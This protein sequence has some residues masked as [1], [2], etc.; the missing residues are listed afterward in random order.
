MPVQFS[1]DRRVGEVVDRGGA[2]EQLVEGAVTHRAAAAAE[3]E[4]RVGRE[5][6]AGR[7]V[8]DLV[9]ADVVRVC[10]GR[11][12]S[13]RVVVEREATRRRAGQVATVA[14][15]CVHVVG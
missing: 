13:G 2:V 9:D 5:R 7:E 14:E 8:V 3:A 12:A 6:G 15:N 11:A 1:V 10:T 4:R